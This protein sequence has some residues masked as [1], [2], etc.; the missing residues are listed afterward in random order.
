M[1]KILFVPNDDIASLL[2]FDEEINQV[3]YNGQVLDQEDNRGAASGGLGHSSLIRIEL[4]D[5]Q[6]NKTTYIQ[7]IFI[8][9]EI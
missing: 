9:R 4:I 5:S 8:Q 3:T 1:A 6:N 2:D 7:K